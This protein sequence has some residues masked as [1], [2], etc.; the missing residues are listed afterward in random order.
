MLDSS[1]HL[2][3]KVTETC[4]LVREGAIIISDDKDFFKLIDFILEYE[5]TNSKSNFFNGKDLVLKEGIPVN[6]SIDRVAR[7][8]GKEGIEG[9]TLK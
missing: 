9:F 1:Q 2:G 5:K 6:Y 4:Y 3:S 8:V 7:I